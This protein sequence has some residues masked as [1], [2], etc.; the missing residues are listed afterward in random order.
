MLVKFSLTRVDKYDEDS[1]GKNVE[2]QWPSFRLNAYYND[3]R[4]RAKTLLFILWVFNCN[5]T[6]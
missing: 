5:V 1:H 2:A 4:M 3:T 6:L